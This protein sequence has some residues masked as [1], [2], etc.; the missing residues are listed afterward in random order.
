MTE[1]RALRY[2]TNQ[3]VR[4]AAA[5]GIIE[6][7]EPFVGGADLPHIGP[8][9][10]DIQ[11]NGGW[12][13][14]FSSDTLTVEQVRRIFDGVQ[15][16]GVT[17]F[18][19]TLT[20][21]AESTL[22]SAA[23]TIA[24][25]LGAFPEYEP[26]VAGLHLEGPFI[27]TADGPRGAH[28]LKY[29][30]TDYDLGLIDRL[31]Q[32]SGKRLKIVTLSPEYDGA[33]AFIRK[34]TERGI[35]VSV[36][37]TNATSEQITE[38]SNA[39]ARLSTHL[40]NGTHPMIPKSGNYFF[41]EL[42]NDALQASIIADG[43]H[44]SPLT[45]NLIRRCKGLE[46]LILVSDQAQV[47]GLAPGKYSTG[48]CDLELLPNGKIVLASDT[49]L[50]AAASAPLAAGI[51]HFCDVS[52]L[53]LAEVFP[54]A[55]THPARLLNLP[56]FGNGDDADFLAVGKPADFFI[57]RVQPAGFDFST[58]FRCGVSVDLRN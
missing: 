18:C 46:R 33:A 8:G 14:E 45:M 35:V 44:V 15:R 16:T 22:L 38:A 5:G 54:L 39:G 47:A 56:A 40:S 10:F 31:I 41:A 52:K 17:R 11:I 53:P 43:F 6:S 13:T 23:R 58:I 12:G 51:V 55:T 37:H 28:P 34:L 26:L 32:A 36:G 1:Y 30:R 19:P 20:T 7:V 48:L 49:R 4:V 25:T 50:L 9:L 2:D 57:F 42:L 24:E 21:N 27:A 3:P 29:C